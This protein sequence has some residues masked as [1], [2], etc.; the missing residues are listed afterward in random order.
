[1][2]LTKEG[3]RI[4]GTLSE[5]LVMTHPLMLSALSMRNTNFPGDGVGR[6]DM[7]AMFIIE[8]LQDSGTE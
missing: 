1:M 7:D 4:K 6:F 5:P 3:D 2:K 8:L